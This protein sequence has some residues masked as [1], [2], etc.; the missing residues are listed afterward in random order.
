ML[1]LLVGGL[2][3]CDTTGCAVGRW[4]WGRLV[5][6]VSLQPAPVHRRCELQKQ[7]VQRSYARPQNC[8]GRSRARA[9]VPS[10][11]VSRFA[12]GNAPRTE[13]QGPTGQRVDMPT[14]LYDT[15][16]RNTCNHTVIAHQVEM[17]K[18]LPDNSVVGRRLPCIA[19]S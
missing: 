10:G 17:P 7:A 13:D 8:A 19:C 14:Q 15:V 11:R 6:E 16:H 3:S 5:G 18:A 1:L 4:G 2:L 9:S 12:S